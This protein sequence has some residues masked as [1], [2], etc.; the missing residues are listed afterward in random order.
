MSR[1]V[2]L[3]D[4]K[5]IM[6]RSVYSVSFWALMA[7]NIYCLICFKWYI[8]DFITIIWIYWCQSVII[9]LISAVELYLPAPDLKDILSGSNQTSKGTN[10]GLALFF[11]FHYG[12][13][14]LVYLVF[15]AVRFGFV[16]NK[17]VLLLALSVF[18]AEALISLNQ[19]RKI[20]L[21]EIKH[22]QLTMLLP[23]LRVIPMHL[24]IIL[25]AFMGTNPN[26]VFIVLKTLVDM[27]SWMIFNSFYINKKKSQ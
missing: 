5:N 24:T 22:T 14:H 11:I 26:L 17:E 12:V 27:A 9:G 1:S 7:G 10:G 16:I 15:V 25:P 19:R 23:Y 20:I 6:Q 21:D 2:F 4:W 3:R 18:L 8:A 13:F